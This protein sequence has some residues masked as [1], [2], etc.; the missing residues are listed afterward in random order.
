MFQES[1]EEGKACEALSHKSPRTAIC[2]PV[3]PVLQER[4]GALHGE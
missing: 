1:R 4:E 3:Y 2:H